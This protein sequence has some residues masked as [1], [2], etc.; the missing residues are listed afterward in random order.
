MVTWA[1]PGEA[2]KNGYQHKFNKESRGLKKK[3]NPYMLLIKKMTSRGNTA[4]SGPST[5]WAAPWQGTAGSC[6]QHTTGTSREVPQ[7]NLSLTKENSLSVTLNPQKKNFLSIGCL[8][9][10][11]FKE[12]KYYVSF[13]RFHFYQQFIDKVRGI[14]LSIGCGV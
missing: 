14:C 9:G 1:P 7:N 6:S 5:R 12:S 4:S 10:K 11:T 3:K 13:A 2:P 8:A